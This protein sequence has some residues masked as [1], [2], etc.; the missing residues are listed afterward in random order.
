MVVS[1]DQMVS[2]AP[3]HIAQMTGI[4]TNK[5]Y[6]YATVYVDQF[7]KLSFVYLQKTA[8][9]EETLD[10]KIA[11]EKYSQTKGISIAAYHADNGIF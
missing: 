10:S 2:P 8:S 6:R 1:V 9:A 4:L 11:F 7:S 5:R 3:G